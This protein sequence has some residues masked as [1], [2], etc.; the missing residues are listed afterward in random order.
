MREIL[1]PPLNLLW[2]YDQVHNKGPWDYKQL[3]PD[4]ADFGNF[5]YGATGAALGLSQDTLLRAAGWAQ[6]RSVN[7]GVG[8][9]PSLSEA[10]LGVGEKPAFGDDP[11]DQDWIKRGIQYYRIWHGE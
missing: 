5:N 7:S 10:I 2:F 8:V 6:T 1:T 4:Y 11:V 9:A 3:D